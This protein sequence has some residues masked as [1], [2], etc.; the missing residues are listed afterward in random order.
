MTEKM[1]RM[2]GT[3]TPKSMLSLCLLAVRRKE[4]RRG[5]RERKRERDVF[6]NIVADT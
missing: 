3:V 5:K 4:R 6:H 2:Q 1:E